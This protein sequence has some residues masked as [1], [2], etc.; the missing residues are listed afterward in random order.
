MGTTIFEK[1]AKK[2]ASRE[3]KACK[4]N[5]LTKTIDKKYLRTAE[6]P[7][8]IMSEREVVQ[9]YTNLSKKN[10]PLDGGFYQLGSCRMKYNPKVNEWAA[11]LD[12]FS[13]IHPNQPDESVQGAL[14]LMYT[15][16]KQLCAITGMDAI[17]LQPEA[18]AH[19]ELTGMMII[20]AYFEKL[21][22][23]KKKVIVPDSAHGTNP[24]S[25][26]MCGFD[27]I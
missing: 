23:E 16:Q 12:G 14:G 22:I 13:N 10:F 15:L 1:S 27:V 17:S 25:S 11:A 5:I 6:I 4:T 18:G 19:G 3:Q 21:G 9:H 26:K 8:P 20:K 24:A 2:T 7:L